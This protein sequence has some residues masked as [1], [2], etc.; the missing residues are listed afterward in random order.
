MH[1]GPGQPLR[2]FRDDKIER[3]VL[4]IRYSAAACQT[5]LVNPLEKVPDALSDLALELADEG[6]ALVYSFD[7]H[8]T[9]IPEVLRRVG[10]QGIA[11]KD[12]RTSESSLEEIFVG[13]VH[14]KEA[15]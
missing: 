10:D 3:A 14:G 5:D 12:L 15:M 2:V 11:F 8:A 6:H 4:D 1:M 9:G 13:L 7:V